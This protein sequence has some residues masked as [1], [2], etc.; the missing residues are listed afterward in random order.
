[1]AFMYFLCLGLRRDR[2]SEAPPGSAVPRAEA[3]PQ[4]AFERSGRKRLSSRQT[5][6]TLLPRGGMDCLLYTSDAADE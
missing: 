3:P 1:M 6:G 5:P 4:C 2:D